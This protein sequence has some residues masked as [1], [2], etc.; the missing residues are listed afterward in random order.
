MPE[1]PKNLDAV[2]AEMR[3]DA[4]VAALAFLTPDGLR[5]YAD[6]IEAAVARERAKYERLHECF[7]NVDSIQSIVRQMLDERDDLRDK[8]PQAS[9]VA[10][11]FA[12]LLTKAATP[13]PGN[14]AALREALKQCGHA[15]EKAQCSSAFQAA[16]TGA[17]YI[18]AALSSA[19]AALAAPARNADR[20]ECKTLPDAIRFGH[21]E[22]GHREWWV[23]TMTSA[24]WHDFA[25]WLFAAEDGKEADHA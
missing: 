18:A 16:N 17:G 25:D 6:L 5:G 23:A 19:R 1:T 7:W 2:L 11:H 12:Q 13:A 8:N 24:N 9:E 10:A 22:C 21:F 3:S 15:L 4:D 20:P 14:V